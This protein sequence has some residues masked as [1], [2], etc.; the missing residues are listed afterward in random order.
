MP[1]VDIPQGMDT[2]GSPGAKTAWEGRMIEE[3]YKDEDVNLN[4]PFSEAEVRK[5][6]IMY[7]RIREAKKLKKQRL[8]QQTEQ[9]EETEEEVE[10]QASKPPVIVEYKIVKEGKISTYLIVRANGS[11]KSTPI[12][13]VSSPDNTANLSDA[14]VYAFL[15]NQPNGSQLVHEDLEQIHEDD[16]EEIDLK[17]QLPLLSMRAR[18]YFQKIGKNITFNGS[19]TTRNQE[20]RPKNQDSSRKTMIVE[21]TSSKAMVAIDQAGFDWSYMADDEF[22]TN[23][24]LMAFSDSEVSDSNED[25]SKEMVLKSKNVQHKPKQAN[26]PR[27]VRLGFTSYNVVAPPPTGLFAPP[28]IDLSNSGLEEFKQPEFEGYG[29]KASKS[30]SV[31]TLNEIKKALMPPIIK[32]WVSDSNDDESKEM[33]LK[34]KNVQHKPKQANQ[35]RNVSQTPRHIRTNWNEIKTQK[36]GVG[37][38]FTKKAYFVCGSFSHLIKDCDFHDKGWN[39]APTAVLTKSGI[40]TIS[41]ARQSSSRAAAPVS[42]AR[43]INTDASKSLVNVAKPRQNALQTTHLLS[44]RPFYQQTAPKNRNLNNNVNAAKANYVN[45]AKGNKVT[46]AIGKQGINGAPQDA[47][48]DKGYFDSR[49]SKHMTGNISYLT[50]FKEHD[51]GYVTFGGG[52]KGG[53][54]TGKGTIRTEFKNRVMNEFCEEKG[55]KREFSMARTPQQ[56]RV[57]E[58]IN[59]TLIKEARTMLAD[60]KLPTTFWAEVVNNACY[61]QNRVLMVKP[62][63]KTLYELFKDNNSLF[64]SS[65]QASNSHNKDKHGPSQASESD[66]HERPNIESSTKTVN[67][68]G[69]VNTATP[70]YAD[71]LNHPLMLDL[72]DTGIFDDD[73]DDRDEGVEA[74]YNNLETV[75]AIQEE[76]LQFKLLNVW[77]LVDLPSGKRAIGTKWV[78]RNK[79]DQRGIVVKNIARLV[80]HGHRQEEGID[81]DEVFAP[82]ARIKAIRVIGNHTFANNVTAKITATNDV[83]SILCLVS[84]EELM[85]TRHMFRASAILDPFVGLQVDSRIK[86]ISV[87]LASIPMETH[88]P[89]SKDANGTDVDVHLYRPRISSLMYLTSSRPDIMFVV[90]AC[91]RFQTK[92]HVDN[93]SAICVV[94]NPVYHSKTKHIEIRHYFIRDSYEKRL[95]EMIMDSGEVK[96]C[97]DLV[98]DTQVIKG[99]EL[100]GYLINDGYV[101]LVQHVDKKELAIPGQTTTGKEFSNPLMADQHNMV[102]YLEKS[103]D[104]RDFHQIVDFLSSCSITY[105]LTVSPTIYASYIEQFYN[106]A[107]SKTIN[108]VKQIHVI[109]DGK[110]VA[111]YESSVR[112]DLLFDDEDGITCLTNDEIFENLALMGYEP[113]S[114]KLTFQKEVEVKK[115]MIMFLKNQ[116]GYKQRHV[117]GMKYEDIRPIFKRVWDQVYTFV[118]KDSVKKE[119]MKR[120][121]FNLQQGSSKKQRLDQQTKQIEEIEEEVEA[122][123]DSDQEI[124]EVKL[125]IRIIPNEDIAIDSIP[126]ATK[127]S[128][129]VEYKIVKEGKISTYLIVRVNRSTKRYTSM[130]NLL[131]NIDKEDLETLWKLVKDKHKDTRPEGGYE[132]VL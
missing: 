79:R 128:V 8:D 35:P 132:R 129:I 21:D 110:A 51:G 125:Y 83:T 85:V 58:R 55:S 81:Y 77:T 115:N 123:G 73:Y 105:A 41:T 50:N 106:T 13:I 44:R 15:S 46:S 28:S 131:E 61:V 124:E 95:I 37:F 48:K 10:A 18:R 29:P 109:V 99:L 66:N 7:L 75:E 63:F 47:L 5:N 97:T 34:S 84:G 80:A 26:Q 42:V 33:V 100:K 91:S 120:A 130:I 116:G 86:A 98:M 88:K 72:E 127:S 57:I 38:Q 71:Y 103:D 126:L 43:P 118:P 82:V 59:K 49:C 39:F 74:D 67:T 121:G 25:E 24:A 94:K 27:N 52:A 4:R 92:I 122:Q 64:N 19:D 119:V 32:D 23:M 14:T 70:I 22:R 60:S 1:N 93:E 9:I 114:T 117:K 107:S 6:M 69:P 40:V 96:L 16:L 2:C 76:L 65:S 11:T 31:D 30:V 90:C 12:S 56:N 102:A 68:V 113:L 36:L 104:S 53:K 101:D 89:L 111:I 3:L 20:S 45:T 112:I 54:I 62:Y 87:K 78:Y 17:W 108:S